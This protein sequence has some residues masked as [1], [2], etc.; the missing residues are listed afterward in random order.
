MP[1]AFE[2]E[3]Y[4][5]AVMMFLIMVLSIAAV[6]IFIRQYKKRCVKRRSAK[7]KKHPRE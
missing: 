6:Y 5:I 7:R 4:F 3:I 1:G 2:A